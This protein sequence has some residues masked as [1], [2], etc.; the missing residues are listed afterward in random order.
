V[1]KSG[2]SGL[3]PNIQTSGGSGDADSRTLNSGVATTEI[4]LL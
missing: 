3:P 2:F 4:G 1:G